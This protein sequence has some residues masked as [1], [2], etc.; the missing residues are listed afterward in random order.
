[1]SRR[2]YTAEQAANSPDGS[3][4]SLFESVSK[5]EVL[6]VT[7]Q[8]G[9]LSPKDI[10]LA[11]A[12]NIEEEARKRGFSQGLAEGIEAGKKSGFQ[13]GH[14]DGQKIALQE[15]RTLTDAAIIAFQNDVDEIAQSM[16]KCLENWVQNA[17][18]KLAELAI[19]T[20]SRLLNCEVQTN[21]DAIVSIAAKAL[22]EA[23]VVSH[24]RI[25]INPF[26]H[27]SLI[28]HKEQI[29]SSNTHLKNIEIIEDQAIIGGCIIESDSGIIDASV[30][31][32][33]ERLEGEAA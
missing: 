10:L 15:A 19:D 31:M 14:Q 1:M 6:A 11:R 21:R 17:Q 9:S 5:E 20:T 27:S 18:E 24:C 12:N 2:I 22:Q 23:G 30:N 29:M 33:L 26:D 32:F 25:K 8:R 3:P 13:S 4:Q 7:K 28:S 16:I